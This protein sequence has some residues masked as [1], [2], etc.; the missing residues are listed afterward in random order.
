[1]KRYVEQ[2][3]LPA[4]TCLHS[5][6]HACATHL[7]QGGANLRH[8]QAILGH[9]HLQSTAVYTRV[10]VRDL[11]QVLEQAHPRERAWRRR[12]AR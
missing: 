11:A 1:M 6:R 5:L 3:R 12:R 4:G 9:A 8:V 7:L 2:A 10:N